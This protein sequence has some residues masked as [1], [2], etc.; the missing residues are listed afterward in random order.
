[1]NI[2][3]AFIGTLPSYSIDTVYQTRLFYD[4]P[5]YFIVSDYESPLVETLKTKY[6]VH[7]IRYDTVIDSE[8]RALVDR[9]YSKFPISLG[10]KGR[11]HLFIY[12]FER[13]FVLNQLMKQ[14]ALTNVL[15]MELDNLIYDDPHKWLKG[16]L[17]HDMSYMFD[18]VNR[19]AS[20]IAFLR[21]TT[22]L[23]E[24]LKGC[25]EFIE[26]TTELLTEM[27]F[28][29][30]FWTTH[31]TS[32]QLLP[33]YWTDPSHP[34]QANATFPIFN[35]VFDAAS[36][37]ICLGGMDPYHTKG[38]IVKGLAGKWSYHDFSKYTYEWKK[39]EKDRLIPYIVRPTDNTRIRINNLHIHSKDLI[40]CLSIPYITTPIKR[41]DNTYNTA[42]E[43]F[44]EGIT[45]TKN[46]VNFKTHPNYTY[47]LEHV[48]PAQGC[49]YLLHIGR[50]T[51]LT[52][53]EIG[54]FCI[55]NDSV[56]N[57]KT[58]YF[59]FM[60]GSP[61]SLRYIL[62]AHL[63]L[64]HLKSLNLPSNDLVEIGGGYG[65]LALAIYHFAKRYD[66]SIHSYTI[67]DLP[68]VTKLQDL[69]MSS[70]MP[71]ANVITVDATTYGASISKRDM[72]L[73]SNYCYSGLSKDHQEKYR[74]TL[75]SKVSHGFM[76]WNHIPIHNF[77]FSYR[78][79]E[80]YPKTDQHNRYVYF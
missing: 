47:V 35:S 39:D 9:T 67:I 36:M 77:G 23:A 11:E 49:Q 55:L 51:D 80:E 72:F 59:G 41:I 56:G 58:A 6:N 19:G 27:I 30:K 54:A 62:H 22:L 17:T 8:F 29:Y 25:S 26:T 45:T 21:S 66:V 34:P 60:E 16:F 64:T 78:D 5:I 76:T 40:P 14:Q 73:I 57:P 61:S 37:G 12:S 7:I 71:S 44:I 20:G 42:Y 4:G 33:I 28:L 68:C 3:Y 69:Y 18:N 74:T 13:F 48:T 70:V 50:K 75:F 43:Y 53:E 38:I 24:F 46:L 1:M 32:V 10:L 31:Q 52:E 15:F 63:I 2:V 79:E 65:G